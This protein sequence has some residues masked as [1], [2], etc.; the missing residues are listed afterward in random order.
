MT[1]YPVPDVIKP[2]MPMIIGAVTALLIFVFGWLLSKWAH[3]ITARLLRRRKFDE[4]MTRFLAALAQYAVLAAAV[5]AALAKVGVETTSLVALLGTIGLAIGLALQGS[6]SHLASGVMLVIFRPFTVGDYVD[7]GGKAGTV[8]EVGLFATTLITPDNH[9]V[10]IPNSSIT[11]GPI[12]NFTVLGQR[13]ASIDVG[14]GYGSDVDQVTQ[15]LEQ[16]ARKCETILDDPGPAVVFTGLGASS[17][18]F[19]VR[20]WAKNEDF[21]PMQGQVRKHVYDTLNEA[22]VDIPFN[23]IVVHE[24]P[25]G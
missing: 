21:F 8:D 3:A 14:V 10:S 25:K 6:L 2:F 12:T 11:G 19:S 13:R 20:V 5:I 16:A 24:A 1:E 18:D 7:A 22:G 15:L 23:Q 4:S 9:R 17:L